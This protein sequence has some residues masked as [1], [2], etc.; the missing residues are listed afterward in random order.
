[1]FLTALGLFVLTAA[2]LFKIYPGA[3][4]EHIANPQVTPFD[5]KAPW[6]FW[7][8]QGMLKL[9][10]KTLMGI[11]L[12]TIILTAVRRALH[13]PQPTLLF[14]RAGRRIG[15]LALLALVVLSYMGLPIYGIQT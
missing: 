5:T 8:L 14:K 1:V 12:P 7:W 2:I 6:Y 11:I 10:D 9:G 4:L 13:R 3:P 15:L